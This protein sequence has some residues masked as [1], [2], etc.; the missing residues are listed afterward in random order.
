MKSLRARILVPLLPLIG[1]IVCL[2]GIGFDRALSRELERGLDARLFVMA[3]GVA[4]AVEVDFE[5]EVEFE[6]EDIGIPELDGSQERAF[7][8]VHDGQGLLAATR[9]APMDSPAE[10]PEAAIY[11]RVV[12]QGVSFR[13]CTAA[14]V[15]E[16]EFEGEE[17]SEVGESRGVSGSDVEPRPS[18]TFVITVGTVTEE[19][20]QTVVSFRRKMIL[21]GTAL[22]VVLMAVPFWVVSRALGGLRRLSKDAERIGPDSRGFRLPE[23]GVAEEVRLLVSSLN[24]AV[25]RLQE[26]HEREKRFSSDVAHELRTP[27]SAIRTGCEV[28]LRRPRTAQDMRER[29]EAV[30]KSSI[31]LGAMVEKM[32]M[33]ARYHRQA[34]Q[35]TLRRTD[36]SEIVREVVGLHRREAREKRLELSVRAEKEIMVRGDGE[37]LR[38]C[39]SNLVHNAVRYTP[40]D[41]RV[42][43]STE[44]GT[45]ARFAVS[46]SGIGIDSEHLEKI[47]DRFYRVDTSRDRSSGSFGLGLALAQEIAQLHG[48]SIQVQSVPGE[49]STFELEFAIDPRVPKTLQPAEEEKQSSPLGRGME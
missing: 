40:E 19:L 26:A 5:G 31:R 9:N 48:C 18:E 22:L 35:L 29:I 21:G 16:A 28:A 11:D 14:F 32:L 1:V 15:L 45:S 13:T 33:L 47:F 4:S 41:G 20:D 34:M 38:E 24:C 8:S 44:N 6:P 42:E 49:G 36:L 30:L 43:V 2:F 37:L 27:L 12:H 39:L 25:D 17:D 7:F 46:D 3:Q 10:T 23:E